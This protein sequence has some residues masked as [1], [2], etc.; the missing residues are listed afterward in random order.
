MLQ[1][2]GHL[3][4]GLRI[5]DWLPDLEIDGKVM[6]R[7]RW[8]PKA[9]ATAGEIRGSRGDY[10]VFY[11]GPESGNT[12]AGHNRGGLWRP[13]DWVRLA[14]LAREAGL[15]VLFVGAA[16]D[17]SYLANYSLPAGLAD[18]HNYLG[19]WQ[20]D[21]TLAVIRGARF[22]VGFQS[23]LGIVGVYQGVPAAMFWRPYGDSILP[24]QRVNFREEMATAWVPREHLAR[25]RYLPCIYGR[26]SPEG[27]ME[28]R[29]IVWQG[30]P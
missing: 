1:A 17:R 24:D 8:T 16:Y 18:C 23:G 14:K 15:A 26:C 5:E 4:R 20:I 10:C 29:R 27:I 9:L 7:F 21:E 19:A 6:E 2:N 30:L 25:G 12:T 3:E 11:A 22:H 13:A 28:H